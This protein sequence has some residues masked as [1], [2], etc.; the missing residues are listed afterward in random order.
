MQNKK[1]MPECLVK[2]V[3]IIE[4]LK[5]RNKKGF[6]YTICKIRLH[7]RSLYS[8]FKKYYMQEQLLI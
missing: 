1:S 5:I 8:S 2:N 7:D 3:Q 6:T 4:Y